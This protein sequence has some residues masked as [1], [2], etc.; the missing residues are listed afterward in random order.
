MPNPELAGR[1]IRASVRG[2][3]YEW[4]AWVV[5]GVGLAAVLAGAAVL[6]L[7][8]PLVAGGGVLAAA[9]ASWF[10]VARRRG[11]RRTLQHNLEVVAGRRIDGPPDPVE[12]ERVLVLIEREGWLRGSFRDQP[13]R[14][15]TR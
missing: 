8:G 10:L 13:K 2:L 14:H 7:P 5:A 4:V 3:A 6:G 9:A 15:A 1:A 11:L 12:A